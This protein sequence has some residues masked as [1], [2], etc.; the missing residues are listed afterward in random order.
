MIDHIF[1]QRIPKEVVA[2][3][4][5]IMKESRKCVKEFPELSDH[6]NACE[7]GFLPTVEQNYTLH[8][9]TIPNIDY[10][11]DVDINTTRKKGKEILCIA[12]SGSG[13][14]TCWTGKKFNKILA[15]KKIL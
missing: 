6:P 4:K 15:K 5:H 8:T 9:H 11:S 12:N 3:S 2:I 13:K 7:V 10:P 1:E 14:L